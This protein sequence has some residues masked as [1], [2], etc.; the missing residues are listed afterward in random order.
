MKKILVTV[1]ALM[2]S[3][4]AFANGNADQITVRC[5]WGVLTMTAIADGFEQGK[6]SSSFAPGKRQGLGNVIERGNLEA[7]CLFI[8]S[9]I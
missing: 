4:T 2:F 6:H 1:L 9:Q 7:T 8:E 5:N 3:G